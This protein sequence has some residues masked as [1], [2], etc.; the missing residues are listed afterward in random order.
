[1]NATLG[2]PLFYRATNDAK[3]NVGVIVIVRPNGH[4]V[5]AWA[6]QADKPSNLQDLEIVT[7]QNSFACEGADG[8]YSLWQ[9]LPA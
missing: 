1:M 2:T 5:S 7:H 8:W 3:V 4:C 6:N 9:A